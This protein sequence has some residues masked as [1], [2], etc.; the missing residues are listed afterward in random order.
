M[1]N[2]VEAL[3]TNLDQNENDFQIL[4]ALELTFA[5]VMF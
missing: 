1:G 5:K 3:M 4:L 2:M